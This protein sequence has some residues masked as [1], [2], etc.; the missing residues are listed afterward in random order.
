LDLVAGKPLPQTINKRWERH[1]AAKSVIAD[2][3]RQTC[4]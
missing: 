1:L 2:A 4:G 3:I